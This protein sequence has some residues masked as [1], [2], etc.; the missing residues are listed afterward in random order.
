MAHDFYR[1]GGFHY[2]KAGLNASGALVVWRNHFISYGEGERFANSANIPGAE[3][4]ATFVPDYYFGSSLIS[5]GIPTG[6]LRAP[7]SNAFCFVF[8][9]FIDEL[10]LAAGKDPLDFRL[11]TLRASRPAVAPLAIGVAGLVAL[12]VGLATERTK[13]RRPTG[14]S[15]AYAVDVDSSKAWITG[16]TSSGSA[17]TWLQQELGRAAAGQK[18]HGRP[19]W[20]TAGFNPRT[21]FPAPFTAQTAPTAVVVKDSVAGGARYVTLRVRAAPGMP[22]IS[23]A[24]SGTDVISA[25]VDGKTV[26]TEHYRRQERPWPL[27]LVAPPD[28]GFLLGLTVRPGTQ[29]VIGLMSRTET[30]PPLEGFTIPQRAA[31]MVSIQFGDV[32]LAY[33]RVTLAAKR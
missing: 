21:T 9:S 28:S 16:N 24:P 7:R 26:I 25:T 2:L 27:Q 10:A 4:P 6:A 14:V 5:F 12:G 31:G 30:I 18:E 1:P 13:P 19:S 32:T 3:Y 8:Q 20:L 15:F 22:A 17:R 33:R 29:P 23:V 11:E